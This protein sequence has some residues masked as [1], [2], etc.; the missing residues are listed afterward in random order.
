MYFYII[1]TVV[2]FMIFKIRLIKSAR[3]MEI[4]LM[5]QPYIIYYNINML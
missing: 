4:Y 2:L 5:L 1:I 3:G